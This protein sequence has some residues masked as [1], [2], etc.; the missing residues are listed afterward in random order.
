ML[1]I[2]FAALVLLRKLTEEH[3]DEWW[4]DLPERERRITYIEV[5]PKPVH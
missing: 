4:D 5:F 3:L 1:Q 2:R